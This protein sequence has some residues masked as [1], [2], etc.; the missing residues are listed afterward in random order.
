TDVGDLERL[1]CG[2]GFQNGFDEMLG[3]G[4]WDQNGGGELE[5]GGVEI[6]LA[7]DVLDG[8]MLEAGREALFVGGGVR[9]GGVAVGMSDESDARDSQGV[10]EEEL[11]VTSCS[12]VEVRVSRELCCSYGE[13]FAECHRGERVLG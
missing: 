6:L 12:G 13:G 11:G 3:F 8:G 5:G 1:V 2:Q 10:E 4:A 9:R 7:G